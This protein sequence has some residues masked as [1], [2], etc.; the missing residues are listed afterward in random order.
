MNKK[1]EWLIYGIAEDFFV[2]NG[3]F[4]I[5]NYFYIHVSYKKK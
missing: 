3:Q 1:N 5:V 2:I 4:L